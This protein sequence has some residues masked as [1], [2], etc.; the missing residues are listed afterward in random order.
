MGLGQGWRLVLPHRVHREVQKKDLPDLRESPQRHVHAGVCGRAGSA[1]GWQR[2]GTL[3]GSETESAPAPGD[4]LTL[5]SLVTPTHLVNGSLSA[6]S[7]PSLPQPLSPSL[8]P[9]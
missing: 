2:A 5:V 8:P 4:P 6:A 9:A 3:A 7:R 1:D